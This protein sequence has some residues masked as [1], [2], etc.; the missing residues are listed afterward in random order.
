MSE[1]IKRL[2]AANVLG[3][4]VPDDLRE[5]FEQLSTEEV[6]A[7]I[8]ISARVNEAAEVTGFQLP[9]PRLAGGTG[10][11]ARPGVPSVQ[12]VPGA[13]GARSGKPSAGIDGDYGILI[14]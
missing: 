8:N 2:Q 1:S 4:E 3:P 11:S 5:V 14:Y 13:P 7:L 10:L 9:G 12:G 6:D